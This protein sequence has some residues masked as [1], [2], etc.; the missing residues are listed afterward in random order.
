MP[1]FRYKARNGRGDA[2]NGEIEAPNSDSVASQLLNSGI[3]PVEIKEYQP[4]Q[5]VLGDLVARLNRHNPTLDD[6]ILFCRQ[7]YTLSKAG[8]PIIRGISGLAESTRNVVL[9]EAMD[10]MRIELESGRELS[11]AMNQFPQF[12]TPLMV[13][14]V[15]I[16]ENTGQLDEAFL[17]LSS[18]LELERDTRNRIKAAMRY[19]SFVLFA[20][21]AAIVIVNIFVIPAFMDVFASFRMELPWQTKLLLATSNFFVDYWPYLLVALLFVLGGLRY[22]VNTPEGKYQWDKKKLR[23]PLIG[24]I[25]TRATLG[26]FA[27]TFAMTTR[28]GVPLIQTLTVVSRAVDNDFVAEQVLSMR[29]GIERGD[30]LTRTAAASG[31]FTPLVLQMMAVGEETGGVDDMLDEVADFYEREVDYELKGLSQAIEPILLVA[32]GVLVLMLALGIFLP[33]WELTSIA[34]Q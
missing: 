7:M 10:R 28:A 13:S 21:A 30:S 16:G 12:F 8:V 11:T 34:K 5:D 17:K 18:Y 22:Y 3:T 15:R 20:I 9:A 31:M 27:R 29:N 24:S 4:R 6:L 32:V 14:M 33:M 2:I 25:L 19:P 23:I 1:Q 26:R